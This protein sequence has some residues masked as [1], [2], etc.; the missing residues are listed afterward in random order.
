MKWWQRA[1]GIGLATSAAEIAAKAEFDVA[2]AWRLTGAR[3]LDEFIFRTGP[4]T[5]DE[6]MA[7]P[8]VKRA[9]DLICGT[10]GQFEFKVIDPK[11]KDAADRFSPNMFQQPEAGVAKSVTWTNVIGDMFLGSRAWLKVTQVGWHNYPAEFRRLIPG[12]VPIQPDWVTQYVNGRSVGQSL[13]WPEVPGLIRVD[14][15]TV[16]VLAACPAVRAC[17]AL[18]RFALI[19]STGGHAMDYFA[20]DG[21]SE[22]FADAEEVREKLL[23]PWEEARL[24]GTTG[25]VPYGVKLHVHDWDPEKLQLAEA[26]EFAITEVA[27]L[28][29]IDAED[30]SV[31]TTS[32]TYFNAQDRRRSRYEVIGMYTKALEGRLSMPD[33]TPRGYTVQIDASGFLALDDLAAAQSDSVLVAS[34]ILTRDEARAKRGLEPLGEPE[35][36][37]DP[38]DV[39]N[40]LAIGNALNPPALPP[41]RAG[42]NPKEI[43]SA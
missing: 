37:T 21:E 17:I 7:V 22:P 42:G 30:L 29:G 14:S 3:T 9:H 43:T 10:P 18:E 36:A 1:L 15:P 32:R 38:A 12:S 26:R 28:T 24:K 25:Y 6:A 2:E 23:D 4:I 34:K 11:G 8:A 40:A 31:S 20:P 5:R 16:G 35:Q 39:G 19:A 27:R 13:V 33:V 41:A